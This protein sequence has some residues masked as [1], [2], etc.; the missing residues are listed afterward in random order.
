MI[1]ELEA[2]GGNGRIHLPGGWTKAETLRFLKDSPLFEL[3]LLGEK[4]KAFTV[5]Y[6]GPSG[7]V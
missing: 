3:S 1:A 7:V 4:G 6:L 5:K 2:Q